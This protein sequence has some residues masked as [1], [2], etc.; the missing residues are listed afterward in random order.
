VNIFFDVDETILSFDGSLRPFVHDVFR[1]LK[2][3]GHAI[4]VW[5]GVG[6]RTEVIEKFQLETYV[7]GCFV[8]PTGDH[9]NRWAITGIPVSPDFCVDD[10][11]DVVEAFGGFVVSP[12]SHDSEDSEMLRVYEAVRQLT[13]R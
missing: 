5:S 8:K 10:Y 1:R 12:Y 6:M 13:S 2:D 9:L 11:A 7:S 4:Y 3:D